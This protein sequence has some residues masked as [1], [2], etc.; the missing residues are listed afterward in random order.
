MKAAII[1]YRE[2]IFRGLRLYVAVLIGVSAIPVSFAGQS[3]EID[4]TVNGKLTIVQIDH[5]PGA[6]QPD[7][8]MYL[9]EDEETH[10][11][12]TLRFEKKAPHH[13]R[14]GMKVTARGKSKGQE[15]LLAADGDSSQSITVNS[16]PAA[17]VAGDQKTL[18]IMANLTDASV[19]CSSDS[20]RDV[21]FSPDASVDGLYREM[22]HGAVSFTGQVAGPYALNYSGATCNYAA[23]TDAADAAAR[24]DGINIDAYPRK[25][26]LMPSVCPFSGVGEVGSNPSRA[27]VFRCDFADTLAHELGHNLGMQHAATP[28]A[29]YGDSSDIMGGGGRPLRQINAPHKEQMGWIPPQELVAVTNN[30]TY[31]IAPLELNPLDTFIPP[32]LKIFKPDTNE[33]YYLSYR[34]PIGFDANPDTS[35]FHGRT[36]IH[37]W[38]GARDTYLLA[39]LA[40]GERFVDSINGITVTQMSHAA[41]RATVHVSFDTGCRSGLPSISLSPSSQNAGPGGNLSYMISV[42]NT[43]S[44]N[45]SQ[46]VFDLR[47]SVPFGWGGSVLPS[48]LTLMPGETGQANLSVTSPTDFPA[49]NYAVGASVWDA[50]QSSRT[51]SASGT[52]GVVV[53][54]DAT[55]PTAPSGLS[56]AVRRKGGVS[57][58]WSPSQDNVAVSGYRVFRNGFLIATSSSLGYVDGSTGSSGTY[59]YSVK[60]F[61]AAGNLSA[62]SNTS[63]VTIGGGTVGTGGG[64]GKGGSKP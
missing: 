14:S 53:Q 55:A 3:D 46:T 33:Y 51:A 26:Y 27:W 21:M 19:T 63:T 38:D 6:T 24:A 8:V 47:Q 20:I 42:K 10:K 44:S 60:A 18:V 9:L 4:V 45:C 36:S 2:L 5:D 64:G 58:S 1:R 34:A 61:D 43:D 16:A 11:T 25:V 59:Q 7:E 35:Y 15:L 31:D 54:T 22:S 12:F 40:D 41:D 13:L 32:T 48:S 39:L 50:N 57:L 37:R 56:A 52:Y 49:G 62:S 30:G 17:M 29:S 23:W 28:G